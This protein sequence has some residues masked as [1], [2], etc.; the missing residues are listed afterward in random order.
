MTAILDKAT[1]LRRLPVL[2]WGRRYQRQHAIHDLT[3]AVIVTL[4]LVPQALA[5]AILSGLPPQVG[6]YASMLP[7]V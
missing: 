5:Y 7:L 4:M 3:A 2:D 6:L 1:W